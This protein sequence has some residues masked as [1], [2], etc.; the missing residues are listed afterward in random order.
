MSSFPTVTGSNLVKALGRLGFT[1]IRIRG[2]HYFVR[3]ADGRC[4]VV[5]VHR[6]RQSDEACWREYFEIA[7]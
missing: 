3:H 7:S 6:G 5:P 4:T 2:S 1:V